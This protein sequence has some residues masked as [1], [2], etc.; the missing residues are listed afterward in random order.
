MGYRV[1]S[2]RGTQF[3]IWATGVL[4]EH[5]VRGYTVNQQRLRELNQTVRLIV[6]TA[7]RRDLSGDEAQALLAVVGKYNRALELLDD[8]DRQRVGKPASAGQVTHVLGYEEALRIVAR[9][10]ERFFASD[11]FGASPTARSSR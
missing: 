1:N 3:R 6:D 10:R 4:R 8:Y 2:R 11:V 5:L 9:L 7:A